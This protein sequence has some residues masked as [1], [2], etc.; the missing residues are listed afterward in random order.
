MFT[1]ITK[2]PFWVNLLS[3]LLLGIILVFSIL[4]LLDFITSH[5]EFYTVP[6]VMNKETSAAIKMLEDKGFDVEVI[7][8]VYTDTARMGIVLKQFPEADSKVKKNRTILLTVN[9]VTL[10]LV[11]MPSLE[12]KSIT[13]AL[14]V[15]E[16][17]HLKLGDTIFKPDFMRGSVLEQ[18]FHGDKIP[19]GAKIP[20]GSRVDLVIGSGLNQ[21]P[22]LV[23]D[24]TGMTFEE[25]QIILQQNGLIVGAVVPDEGI[26][27]TA[28]AFVWK[29]NPPSVNEENIPLKI[30]PGQLM[31]IW[32]SVLP[33]KDSTQLNQ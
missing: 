6:S 4:K 11:D 2:R 8:S 10:P 19:P 28:S 33:K 15:L 22:V 13:Y 9:R 26:V 3:A 29:Q 31:D 24:L 16:R 25:A 5:G 17:S 12:G 23:P 30:Q 14:F 21:E 32:L 20:W 7:D 27:D 18:N 1:F